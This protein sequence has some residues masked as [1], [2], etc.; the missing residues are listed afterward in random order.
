[1]FFLMFLV[2]TV[3]AAFLGLFPAFIA[4]SKG[5]GFGKWWFYGWMLFGV[6]IIH[7]MFISDDG[8]AVQNK[9]RHTRLYSILAGFDFLLIGIYTVIQGIRN[10]W[11]AEPIEA[12]FC[13]A[14]FAFAIVLLIGKRNKGILAASIFYALLNLPNVFYGV[15][16]AL[17]SY[18]AILLAVLSAGSMLPSL[19]K[20]AVKMVKRTWFLPTIYFLLS[21]IIQQLTFFGGFSIQQLMYFDTGVSFFVSLLV[22]SI[23]TFLRFVSIFL[24]GLWLQA[25][26][27]EEL[28]QEK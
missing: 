1:M 5:H 23:P 6:A 28:P 27:E 18:G 25:F 21:Y 9:A 2:M 3:V 12:L 15:F 7:V 24:I 16:G 13:A 20:N 10:G 11:I 22:A 14:M 4:K 17:S 26:P 19:R 8:P